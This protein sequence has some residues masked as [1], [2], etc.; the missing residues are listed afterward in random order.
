MKGRL[1]VGVL[2][3]AV[4]PFLMG[5]TCTLVNCVANPPIPP[6]N[7]AQASRVI[8]GDGTYD[9][10]DAPG[11]PYQFEAVRFKAT[12]ATALPW[13]G[14]TAAG[15]GNWLCYTTNPTYLDKAG[16]P[17]DWTCYGYVRYRLWYPGPPPTPGPPLDYPSSSKTVNVKF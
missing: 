7:G 13:D 8:Y 11:N 16:V 9:L 6:P 17:G 3:F 12:H 10:K 1:L 2:V 4:V 14:N 5:P 15:G